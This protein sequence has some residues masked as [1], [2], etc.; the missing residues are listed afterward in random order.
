MVVII[1]DKVRTETQ[2]LLSAIT[3]SG[4]SSA[5]HLELFRGQ[6]CQQI[7][8]ERLPYANVALGTAGNT[9]VPVL[10]KLQFRVDHHM[11]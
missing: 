8:T 7:F 1:D 5:S 2:T 9:T 10:K 6:T 3:P 4:T 11:M